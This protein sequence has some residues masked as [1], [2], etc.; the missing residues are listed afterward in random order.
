MSGIRAYRW[1]AIVAYHKYNFNA[2]AA[3]LWTDDANP[4]R[5]IYAGTA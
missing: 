3:H 4:Q 5:A 2:P 1:F